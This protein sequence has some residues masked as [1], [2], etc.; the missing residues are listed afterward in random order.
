[1]EYYHDPRGHASSRWWGGSLAGLKP[2]QDAADR[3]KKSAGVVAFGLLNR[4]LRRALR[5][6]PLHER[7]NFGIL[8]LPVFAALPSH[9]VQPQYFERTRS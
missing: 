2:R 9:V 5:V 6:K 4:C 3:L 7:L 8:G 1:M